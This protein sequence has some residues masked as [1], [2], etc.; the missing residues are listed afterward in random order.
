MHSARHNLWYGT[1]TQPG[2]LKMQ[3]ERPLGDDEGT[4][5][6]KKRANEKP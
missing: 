3:S 2:M 5:D 4:T 1:G 6:V